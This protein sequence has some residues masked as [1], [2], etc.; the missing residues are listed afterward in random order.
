MRRGNGHRENSTMSET[1][2]K[3]RPR[4]SQ[5]GLAPTHDVTAVDEYGNIRDVQIAGEFPD[6]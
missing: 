2:P 6:R 1:K 3:Y 4:M 5:A